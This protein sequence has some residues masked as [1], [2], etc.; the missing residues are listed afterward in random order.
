SEGDGWIGWP[1]W[2]PDGQSLMFTKGS[3][4][5]SGGM[6]SADLWL[7]DVVSGQATQLT[8]EPGFEGMAFWSPSSSE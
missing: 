5:R 7:Y 1:Q 6:P 4:S 3:L 2:S 8:N